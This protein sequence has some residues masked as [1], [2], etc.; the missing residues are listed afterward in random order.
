MFGMGAFACSFIHFTQSWLPLDGLLSKGAES[1]K[2]ISVL[3]VCLLPGAIQPP[4]LLKAIVDFNQF[5]LITKKVPASLAP[6][7]ITSSLLGWLKGSYPARAHLFAAASMP[8]TGE[9][10]RQGSRPWE[11]RKS[12]QDCRLKG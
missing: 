1:K 8:P 11:S 7:W 12:P 9:G 2:S 3:Q 4:S 6:A 5:A 10:T